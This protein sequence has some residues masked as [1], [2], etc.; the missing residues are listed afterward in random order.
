M[1]FDKKVLLVLGSNVG[2]T[3]IVRYAS[4][5]GAYTIVT[6]FYPKEK[7]PAKLIADES[8]DISTADVEKLKKVILEK[9]VTGVW[10][11]VSE[12][13]LMKAM[14]LC[15][16]FHFPFYCTKEQWDSIEN[17]SMFRLKCQKFNVPCPITYFIGS[18]IPSY[19][20]SEFKYPLVLKPIDSSSSKGVF[21]CQTENELKL[22]LEE[23]LH[24]S[25]SNNIII[26]EFFKGDEFSAH[27]T[28]TNGKVSF[29]SMDNRYPIS[30][31]E[32]NV[33]TI[34]IARIYPSTFLDEYVKQVNNSVISLCES[35]N[36]NTGVIFVQ[37]LYNRTTNKFCI[38]EAGLRCAGEA[39][40]RILDRVNGVNFMHNFVDYA[41]LGENTDF[42]STKENPYMNGKIC[43]VI[44][45]VSRGGTVG[46]I[47][48]LEETSN[49]L[50]S[51]IDYECR[52]PV[53][54]E[55]PNG[56]T[57]RQIMIRFILV[58]DS[59]KQMISDINYINK[60]VSVF[61]SFGNELCMKFNSN[62]LLNEFV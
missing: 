48:G 4:A 5:N 1:K 37:G 28:I 52:Y 62:R 29:S 19:K 22:H 13:N 7:S 12:F 57:L 25:D 59:M 31:H 45:F 23:S 33:T 44:S 51:I 56:D 50:N 54:S 55:T 60:N 17:K 53:G 32:G 38:F 16:Y 43:G 24:Y 58:C 3:D 15:N 35:L 49:A 30:I 18:E 20:Y 61:D 47:I 46:K 34:P 36:L 6:D 40:Y 21:I 2:S 10:A 9:G 26:E 14:E 39:P 8:I 27:Y 41:L 11:G 42:D